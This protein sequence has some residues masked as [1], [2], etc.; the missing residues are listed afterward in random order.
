M[1]HNRGDHN[2][3]IVIFRTRGED[4]EVDGADREGG[5]M[6]DTQERTEESCG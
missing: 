6:G 2:R 5:R 1:F 4:H 3:K